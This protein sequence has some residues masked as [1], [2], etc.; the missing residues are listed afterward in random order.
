[1]SKNL[2]FKVVNLYIFAPIKTFIV[3]NV[4]EIRLAGI[5]SVQNSLITELNRA[6]PSSEQTKN[7]DWGFEWCIEE[8]EGVKSSKGVFVPPGQNTSFVMA[9]LIGNEPGQNEISINEEVSDLFGKN[10]LG[11]L[12]PRFYFHEFGTAT[13][14]VSVSLERDE[15]LTILELEEVSETL[16]NLYKKYFEDIS[17]QLAEA[18]VK[19]IQKL[20]IPYY[21]LDF[22]P[23]INVEEKSSICLPWTHRIYH[24]HDPKLF[25]LPNPGESFKFLVTPS[26][27]MD[28]KDMSIYDNRYIYFGW[29]H[30]LIFTSDNPDAYFQSSRKVSDY[31]RVVEIAQ[32]KWQSLDILEDFVDLM[33]VVFGKRT[34][35]L[36]MRQLR[37]LIR[38]IKTFDIGFSRIM[39]YYTGLKITF[40]TEMRVLLLELNERWL[41]NMRISKIYQRLKDLEKLLDDFSQQRKDRQDDNLNKVVLFLAVVSTIEVYVSIF[42]IFKPIFDFPPLLELS[43][44]GLLT[45]ISVI[46]IMIILKKLDRG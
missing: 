14:S 30:S 22:F 33:I 10:S 37:Q 36:S 27:Q 35:G 8:S 12:E 28:V 17:Y 13:C 20:K 45:A 19:T 44:I 16:N 6:S 18:Y 38:K 32:A 43:A 23:S 29:G 7:N 25:D 9:K 21:Q 5:D 39:D 4:D 15:G 3:L 46:M 42:D 40:D 24:I 1:M 26:R 2:K 11:F 31:V 34:T 41:T